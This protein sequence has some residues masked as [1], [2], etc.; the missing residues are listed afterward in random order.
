MIEIHASIHIMLHAHPAVAH[1]IIH[2][3]RAIVHVIIIESRIVIITAFE[4]TLVIIKVAIVKRWLLV[5]AHSESGR[6]L[7]HW[8]V[9]LI[10]GVSALEI[11]IHAHAHA[12]WTHVS[13]RQIC[14]V[15]HE[16][17]LE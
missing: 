3:R 6:D 4:L 1:V 8:H 15:L 2:E 14:K 17:I 10:E 12:A 7:I 5:H 13:H 16:R 9:H 11:A